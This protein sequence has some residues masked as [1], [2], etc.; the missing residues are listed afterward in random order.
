MARAVRHIT[1]PTR[2][3]IR[4]L[5][6]HTSG[7]LPLSSYSEDAVTFRSIFAESGKGSWLDGYPAKRRALQNGWEN[8]I[9]YHTRLPFTLIRKIVNAA[10][11]YRIH[12][13][14]PLQ[15][16]GLERLG[17]ILNELGFDMRSELAAIDLD[18][19]LPPIV[20]PPTALLERLEQYNLHEALRT[21]P[22]ELFRDGHFNEAVRRAAERYED[23]VRDRSRLG[24]HGR[25]LM[26]SAFRPEGPSLSLT[27]VEAENQRDFQEG[28]MFLSMGMMQAIRNVFSH[29]DEERRPPE[30]CFETLLFLNW[31]FKHLELAEG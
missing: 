2:E 18:E 11:A 31:L 20:L 13:R 21:E 24:E 28:F 19:E 9:R 6:D 16:D 8:V 25:N 17:E 22:L 15:H 4:Q 3:L 12:E 5:V 23:R 29:G 10:I 1:A 27:R 7:F 26:A 14:D 30:E